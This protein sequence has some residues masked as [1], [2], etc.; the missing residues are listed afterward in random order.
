MATSTRADIEA[1]AYRLIEQ[2]RTSLPMEDESIFYQLS[3]TEVQPLIDLFQAVGA[4]DLADKV[5]YAHAHCDSE[6]G[7][8]HHALYL[9]RLA[10]GTICPR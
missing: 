1:A 9:K 2:W 7:D 3:C 10:E 5:E 4:C 8:E 6:P